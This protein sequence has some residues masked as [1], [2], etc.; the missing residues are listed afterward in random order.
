MIPGSVSTI[1]REVERWLRVQSFAGFTVSSSLR[2]LRNQAGW[3]GGCSRGKMQS[4]AGRK[5]RRRA[6]RGPDTKKHAGTSPWTAPTTARVALRPKRFI[7]M[8]CPGA[9]PWGAAGFQ[10]E[11]TRLSDQ[12]MVLGVDLGRY[13]M[14]TSRSLLKTDAHLV[15]NRSINPFSC[16]DGPYRSCSLS[17][18]VFQCIAGPSCAKAPAG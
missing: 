9:R 15:P 8:S 6:P 1:P 5:P 3:P 4:A 7:L 16:T 14:Y 13:R 17:F 12:D 11:R 2:N 10:Q 18:Q